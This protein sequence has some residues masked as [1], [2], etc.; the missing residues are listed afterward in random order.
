MLNT[1]DFERRM[2]EL[3]SAVRNMA[4][5]LTELHQRV[6]HVC[7]HS[8]QIRRTYQSLMP[9]LCGMRPRGPNDASSEQRVSTES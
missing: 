4:T 3:D 1:D 2:N 6:A 9:S 7:D 8:D 5:Y